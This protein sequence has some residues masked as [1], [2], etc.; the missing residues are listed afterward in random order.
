MVGFKVFGT[1]TGDFGVHAVIRQDI[2]GVATTISDNSLKTIIYRPSPHAAEQPHSALRMKRYCRWYPTAMNP[3]CPICNR[4]MA[5]A[6]FGHQT[7]RCND[8][9]QIIQFLDVNDP[10]ERLPWSD[11]YER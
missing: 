8:C 4:E 11:K 7:F 1:H 3:C 10:L 9:R 2:E 6:N 5:K